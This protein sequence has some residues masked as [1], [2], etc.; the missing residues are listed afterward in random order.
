MK[1]YLHEAN[2]ALT[3]THWSRAVG[4]THWEADGSG[5]FSGAAMAT[6]AT[7]T[8]SQGLRFLP[9]VPA[10]EVHCAPAPPPAHGWH[11]CHLICSPYFVSSS[12]AL[13]AAAFR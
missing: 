11:R 13:L 8:G 3:S 1:R 12:S 10:A 6:K 9:W 7:P 2:V 5:G 4:C